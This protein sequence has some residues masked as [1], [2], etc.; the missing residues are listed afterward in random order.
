[1]AGL[2]LLKSP[3][4]LRQLNSVGGDGRRMR[5]S[6]MMSVR[7][8]LFLTLRTSA[9][10]AATLL[11]R[12]IVVSLMS[13]LLYPVCAAAQSPAVFGGYEWV[14]PRFESSFGNVNF[15]PHLLV[16]DLN[17]WKAGATIPIAGGLSVVGQADG[18]YGKPF[19]LGLV[20]HRM[21]T[22]RPW[23]YTYEG[24]PRYSLRP[25]G[26][27]SPFVEGMLG[28]MHGKLG[29][30]GVDFI[31]VATD[32]GVE[33]GVSGGVDVHLTHSLGLQ[34]EVGY[35]RARLFSQTIQRVQVAASGVWWFGAK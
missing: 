34:G 35:R 12:R 23:M 8:W 11:V 24:G 9:R 2:S 3:F 20:V 19:G 26:R 6:A 18:V 13:M 27:V 21:G 14:R 32:T 31:G 4:V 10:S 25:E 30:L 17:G 1:L 15:F 28:V 16:E 5:F 33:G 7:L 22:A 29:N